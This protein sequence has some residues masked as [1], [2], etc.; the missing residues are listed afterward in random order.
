MHMRLTLA[1]H[2]V[3]DMKFGNTMRLD[4]THIRQVTHNEWIDLV[5]DWSPDGRRLAFQSDSGRGF[6]HSAVFTIR[7]DGSDRRRVTPWPLKAGSVDWAP[8][9][10][11]L[12]FASNAVVTEPSAIYT[13]KAEGLDSRQRAPDGCGHGSA[14]GLESP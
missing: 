3:S 7:P 4:G 5:P 2:P 13:I 11:R 1:Y 9:G 12:A 14:G 6:E 10:V 8:G